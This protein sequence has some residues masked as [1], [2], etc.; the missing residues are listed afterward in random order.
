MIRWIPPGA[1]A[2]LALGALSACGPAD[3]PA[4]SGGAPQAPGT[5][6]ATASRPASSPAGPESSPVI[7]EGPAVTAT[8]MRSG[9]GWHVL[10]DIEP[11]DARGDAVADVR[12]TVP[13]LPATRPAASTGLWTISVAVAQASATLNVAGSV[14]A[15][16][17]WTRS[18]TV[19]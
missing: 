15:G 19:P 6:P 16:E 8:S 12:L 9:S 10:I 1:A 14:R 3:G 11:L 13:E 17:R 7:A 2:V 4:R 5:M 18:V